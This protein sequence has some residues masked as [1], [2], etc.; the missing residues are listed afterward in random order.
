MDTATDTAK[1]ISKGKR[2]RAD[3]TCDANDQKV[4]SYAGG[5]VALAPTFRRPDAM[6]II[7]TVNRFSYISNGD[8]NPSHSPSVDPIH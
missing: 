4:Q 6:M 2:N 1:H 7:M 8:E 3:I 5:S